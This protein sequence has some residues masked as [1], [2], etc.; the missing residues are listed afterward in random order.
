LNAARMP[1]LS[2]KQCGH[3]RAGLTSMRRFSKVR[4]E[5]EC[6]RP[7]ARTLRRDTGSTARTVRVPK[8]RCERCAPH[9]TVFKPRTTGIGD[10]RAHQVVCRTT[11]RS[12][13]PSN[14]ASSGMGRVANYR[15]CQVRITFPPFDLSAVAK[16]GVVLGFPL[17]H[18]LNESANNFYNNQ[19]K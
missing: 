9:E 1:G 12:G 19:A 10:P 15:S 17:T 16:R 18:P 13:Q 11:W 3:E 8:L 7:N 4:I 5:P 2:C 6:S 14:T